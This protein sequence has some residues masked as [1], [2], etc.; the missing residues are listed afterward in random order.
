MHLYMWAPPLV[1]RMLFNDS[2]HVAKPSSIT[3]WFWR[4]FNRARDRDDKTV[5][6]AKTD[7]FRGPKR[8]YV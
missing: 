7:H 6:A 1:D 5:V 4:T 3:H 2:V 8:F